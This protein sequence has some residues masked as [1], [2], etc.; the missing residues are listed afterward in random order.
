[1]PGKTAKRPISTKAAPAAIGPYSQGIVCGNL[2]FISGQLPIDPATGELV[3]GSIQEKT[4]RVIEN[5][6]AIAEEAG[7]GLQDIVKTTVFL[8]DMNDFGAVNAV[9]AETFPANPPARAA[10][11]VAALPKDADIEIEAI[12]HLPRE[13]VEKARKLSPMV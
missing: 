5:I 13:T 1:M 3:S 10:I 11:Q 4:H 12:V 2:L 8:K 7:G 6:R 9:Y